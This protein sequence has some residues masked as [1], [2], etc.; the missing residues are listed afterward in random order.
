M[1]RCVRGP[2]PALFE[3]YGE[4]VGRSYAE[5]RA[6]D[7]AYRFQWPQRDGMNLGDAARPA[8]LAMTEGR[9]SYC[10]GAP[11]DTSKIDHFRPK[12]RLEFYRLVCDWSNLFIACDGCNQAKREQWDDGLLRPDEPDFEFD[13]YFWFVADSGELVPNP[14]ASVDDQQRAHRTIAIMDL[15]RPTR[16][17]DRAQWWRLRRAVAA[18]AM[19][20]APYRFL[21][22]T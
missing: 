16:C 4:E 10:D 8:L 18:E 20:D 5:R 21:A 14:G 13:R 11:L 12:G 22:A 15:N 1:F 2:A 9:C 6:A 19:L 17:S 7:P 3:R